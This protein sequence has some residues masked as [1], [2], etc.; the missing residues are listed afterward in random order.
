MRHIQL[1]L[2]ELLK[3]PIKISPKRRSIALKMTRL[4]EIELLAPPYVS[5]DFLMK[6]VD[7]RKSW[8]KK[9]ILENSQSKLTLPIDLFKDW[10]EP[11]HLSEQ[12]PKI[13]IDGQNH[14]MVV[15]EIRSG[16]PEFH[17][18]GSQLV[19][20]YNGKS[21]SSALLNHFKKWMRSEAQRDF[22]IRLNSWSSVM[23]LNFNQ[24]EIK[25]FK[26][27]WGDCN[28]KRIIRMNWKAYACPDWVRDSLCIHELAHLVEMNHSA[29]F[30][31]IV[32]SYDSRERESHHWLKEH[33]MI[34][35]Y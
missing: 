13:L 31:D 22:D 33:A 35:E 9:R 12:E 14:P 17:L 24:F 4:G 19:L 10:G 16:L 6:F 18:N 29:K 30:Y 21:T 27:R 32:R 7:S 26:S 34:L 25:S 23:G 11:S 20:D 1:K 8:I 5:D 28:S 3:I 15:G 2:P